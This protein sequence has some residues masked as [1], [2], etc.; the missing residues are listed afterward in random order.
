M[1]EN[2]LRDAFNKISFDKDFYEQVKR[3]VYKKRK[4]IVKTQKRII[5]MFSAVLIFL[6]G[7]V[8]AYA[9]SNTY[10]EWFVKMFDLEN[11]N[12]GD[13]NKEVIGGDV[14]MTAISYHMIDNTIVL[15]TTFEKTNKELF[16]NELQIAD[17]VLKE[18]NKNIAFDLIGIDTDIS[19]DKQT[20][21]S[22]ITFH[23]K[24]DHVGKHLELEINNI[25]NLD[26]AEVQGT[27]SVPVCFDNNVSNYEVI[28]SVNPI[29]F[30]VDNKK[31]TVGEVAV[32]D[33]VIMFR[34][35]NTKSSY[36]KTNVLSSQYGG[37]VVIEYQDGTKSEELYCT[38]N[39]NGDLIAWSWESLKAKEIKQIYLQGKAIIK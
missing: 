19:D 14:K 5:V 31:Y 15:L 13:I 23:L 34:T 9:F 10:R 7:N 12:I 35:E 4:R 24:D 38:P 25:Y 32:A 16:S 1:N 27:W 11:D 2:E 18:N 22:V 17:I 30:E 26:I 37:T 33:T 6:G 20:L 3:G 36:N 28:T 39:T 29:E 21:M 8:S